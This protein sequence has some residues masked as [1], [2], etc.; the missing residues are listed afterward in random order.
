MGKTEQVLH[1]EYDHL[2]NFFKVQCAE[3]TWWVRQSLWRNGQVMFSRCKLLILIQGDAEIKSIYFLAAEI[4]N[5][6]VMTKSWSQISQMAASNYNLSQLSFHRIRKEE[7]CQVG[8]VRLCFIVKDLHWGIVLL[9]PFTAQNTLPFLSVRVIC[10]NRR[11]CVE[12]WPSSA[13]RC[14]NLVFW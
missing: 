4:S 8:H 11:F 12:N 10:K 2:Y 1:L 5:L 13:R 9:R 14:I 3:V 6:L 7:I